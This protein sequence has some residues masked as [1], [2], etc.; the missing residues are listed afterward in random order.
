MSWI[1]FHHLVCGLEARIG[2]L[3]NRELLVVCF[4]R[5]N[6]RSIGHQGEMDSWVRNEVGL[7]FGQV[8]VQC[9]IESQGGCDGGHYLS[10]EAIQ[11]RVGRSLDVQVPSTDVVNGFVVHHE[12]AV[13]VFQGGVS[14]ENGIVGLHN[15]S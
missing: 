1:A 13:G 15:G 5:R 2:D 4:L 6:D 14:S 3:G 10:D 7:E 8:D 9:T 11:I 12:S